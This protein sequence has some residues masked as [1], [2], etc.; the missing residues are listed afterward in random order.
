MQVAQ[1]LRGGGWLVHGLPVSARSDPV[2]LSGK[3]PRSRGGVEYEMI[4]VDD[5]SRIAWSYFLK[6]KSRNR[7]PPKPFSRLFRENR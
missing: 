6:N 4:I 1:R 7:I 3:R 2:G 5:Y